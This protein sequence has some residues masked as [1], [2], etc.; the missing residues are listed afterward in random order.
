MEN[1]KGQKIICPECESI[2][3]RPFGHSLKNR[4][5]VKRYICADCKRITMLPKVMDNDKEKDTRI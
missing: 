4:Q 1:D 2:N 3:L 5:L